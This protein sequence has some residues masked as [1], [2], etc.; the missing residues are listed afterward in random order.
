MDDPMQ[1]VNPIIQAMIQNRNQGLEVAKLKQGGQQFKQEQ[2]LRQQQQQDV[3]KQIEQQHEIASQ[4]LANQHD[5]IQNAI[6][7]SRIDSLAKI[8]DFVR[9]G[10]DVS[11]L[12]TVDFSNLFSNQSNPASPAGGGPNPNAAPSSVSPSAPSPAPSN[13]Q[14]PLNYKGIMQNGP[15]AQPQSQ[16]QS[17]VPPQMSGITNSIFGTQED[18]LKLLKGQAQAQA[19]GAA[20]GA[21]PSKLVEMNRGNAYQQARDAAQN[22]FQ[23]EII[24]KQQVQEASQNALQRTNQ[25]DIAKMSR[26]TQMAIAQLDNSTKLK[27]I[28][29]EYLTDPTSAT[30]LALDIFGGGQKVDLGNPAMLKMVANGGAAGFK[31]PGTDIDQLKSLDKAETSLNNYQDFVNKYLGTSKVGAI[32]QSIAGKVPWSTEAKTAQDITKGDLQEIGH[33]IEGYPNGRALSSQ[34][35]AESQTTPNLSDTKANGQKKVDA[36][37]NSINEQRS[38]IL[39]NY[40]PAQIE[41]FKKM[42]P[43]INL[44]STAAAP[45]SSAAPNTVNKQIN[46]SDLQ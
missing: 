27:Q 32:G 31:N 2:A 23:R 9:K 35:S 3:E 20:E 10:G 14:S 15:Q 42:N 4:Q 6:E 18:Y 8:Q 41:L 11:K 19:E 22:D 44:S 45:A 34:F 33:E 21:L 13:V 40:S 5:Q 1:F 43:G 38:L 16:A 26:G 30:G 12:G 7:S 36:M 46:W 25:L 37:R 17:Q 28:G 29:A 39:K 24:N